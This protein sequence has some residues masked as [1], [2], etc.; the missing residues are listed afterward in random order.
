[1]IQVGV[2][3]QRGGTLFDALLAF[4]HEHQYCGDLDAAVEGDRVWMTCP[5]RA[6]IV[7]ALETHCLSPSARLAGIRPQP[8]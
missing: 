5:C 1:L 6:G 3:D 7:R 8:R 2:L 4:F